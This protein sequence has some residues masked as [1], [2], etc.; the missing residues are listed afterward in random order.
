MGIGGQ[1]GAV[2]RNQLGGWG[3]QRPCPPFP[4]IR[5]CSEEEITRKRLSCEQVVWSS[6]K[7]RVQVELV[8][9]P[10]HLGGP[11]LELSGWARC[12]GCNLKVAGRELL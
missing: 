7:Q 5:D 10:H 2:L 9:R 12:P 1:E 6:T 11:H 8:H 3:R 4:P